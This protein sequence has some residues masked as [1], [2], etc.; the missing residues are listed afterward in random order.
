MKTKIILTIGFLLLT[1]SAKA[2]LPLE[3]LYG[4]Y[5]NQDG[6]VIQVY[7]GGCTNRSSFAIRKDFVKGV[8]QI[9]FYRVKPD[10]CEA[11]F[12]YGIFLAFTYEEL[13]LQAHDRFKIVNPR[14]A[15]RVIW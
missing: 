14:V 1:V 2:Q 3:S 5:F 8:Q 15:P 9:S 13:G 7:S 12:K 6:I 10:L 4:N 11:L